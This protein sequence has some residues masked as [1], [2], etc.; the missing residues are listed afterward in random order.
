MTESV[1]NIVEKW[2]FSHQKYKQSYPESRPSGLITNDC[3]CFENHNVVN[4]GKVGESN[5][6]DYH[7][8]YI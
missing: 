7:I 8:A 1:A 2:D 3:Y 5:N 4:D 6:F